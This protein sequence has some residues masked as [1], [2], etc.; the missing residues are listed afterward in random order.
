M[1][2]EVFLKCYRSHI[3]HAR[4]HALVFQS[5]TSLVPMQATQSWSGNEASLPHIMYRV[6]V[7]I[8]PV[9]F[10][11]IL[12]QLTHSHGMNMNIDTSRYI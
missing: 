10:T 11:R 6:P 1:F 4:V 9:D 2:A 12:A 3:S 5:A 7:W 8:S